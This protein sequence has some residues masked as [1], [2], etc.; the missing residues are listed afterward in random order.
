MIPPPPK[1][2]FEKTH[3]GRQSIWSAKIEIY[4]LGQDSLLLL[5]HCPSDMATS[6]FYST[7]NMN[8][9]HV[10]GER[11]MRLYMMFREFHN[12]VRIWLRST[13][14]QTANRSYRAV[15]WPLEASCNR[16][17]FLCSFSLDGLLHRE[18]AFCLDGFAIKFCI[19][20]RIRPGMLPI[21]SGAKPLLCIRKIVSRSI[22]FSSLCTGIGKSV[23]VKESRFEERGRY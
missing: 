8:A 4:L 14:N 1:S 5:F 3:C 18:L 6:P 12:V 20:G 13:S 17:N 11:A 2:R 19:A 21:M 7:S 9:N 16:S 22:N 15:E 10:F 23:E